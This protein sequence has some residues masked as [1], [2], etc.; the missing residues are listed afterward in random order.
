MLVR[1]TEREERID[2]GSTLGCVYTER[3][4]HTG[5]VRYP[6]RTR[7]NTGTLGKGIF[8]RSFLHLSARAGVEALARSTEQNGKLRMEPREQFGLAQRRR[9]A[10]TMFPILQHFFFPG[11]PGVHPWSWAV[12]QTPVLRNVQTRAHT[13]P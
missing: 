13:L 3:R 7:L 1:V 10:V 12:T 2:D 6:K 5:N 11:S 8:S 9:S 4:W